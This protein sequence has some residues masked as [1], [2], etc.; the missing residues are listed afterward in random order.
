MVPARPYVC[1]VVVNVSWISSTRI[2]VFQ[3]L[4]RTQ[5]EED[6][7]SRDPNIRDLFSFLLRTAGVDSFP[8]SLFCVVTSSAELR[9]TFHS[10]SIR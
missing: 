6:S 10:R 7:P 5:T 9:R 2:Y 3:R 4:C 8:E 1:T